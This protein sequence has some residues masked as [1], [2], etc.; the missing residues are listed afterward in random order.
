MFRFMTRTQDAMPA[1]DAASRVVLWSGDSAWPEALALADRSASEGLRTFVE[2][3]H[4]PH[5]AFARHGPPRLDHVER[6]KPSSLRV[7]PGRSPPLTI[8][9]QLPLKTSAYADA[10]LGPEAD[11]G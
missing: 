3:R 9:R 6:L 2:S 4:R 1:P 11:W 7:S 10:K 8:P 5:V